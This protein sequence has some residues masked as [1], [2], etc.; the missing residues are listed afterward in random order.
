MHIEGAQTDIIRSLRT[1]IFEKNETPHQFLTT[2]IVL[3]K[4]E[5]KADIAAERPILP[6]PAWH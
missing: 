4:E 3:D 5:E 1:F 2:S 6:P